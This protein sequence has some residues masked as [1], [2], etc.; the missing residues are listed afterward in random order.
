[1]PTTFTECNENI[2]CYTLIG[3]F[4]MLNGECCE[5]VQELRKQAHSYDALI[6]QS[7]PVETDRI[8][9][10]LVKNWW[11]CMVCHTACVKS[12]KRTG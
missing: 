1:M 7:F 4:Q 6:L 5:H 2:T 11:M 8:T 12:R 3:V 10:G 9:K